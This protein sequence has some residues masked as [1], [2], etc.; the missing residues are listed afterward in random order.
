MSD[1]RDDK[2][3]QAVTVDPKKWSPIAAEFH[4]R[5]EPELMRIFWIL[6]CYNVYT[7]KCKS[8]YSNSIFNDL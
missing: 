2:E 1:P 4:M 8:S 6:A 5:L 7:R 3:A